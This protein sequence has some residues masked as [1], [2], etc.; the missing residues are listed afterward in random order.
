LIS[1][2]PALRATASLTGAGGSLFSTYGL[3]ASCI[4]K[5]SSFGSSFFFLGG[6]DLTASAFFFFLPPPTKTSSSTAS[7]G[8]SFFYSTILP[9]FISFVT[10]SPSF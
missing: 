7:L 4:F 1:G 6:A 10:G 5:L 2:G 3:T 9:S 8:S